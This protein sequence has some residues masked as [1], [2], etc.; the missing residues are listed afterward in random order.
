MRWLHRSSRPAPSMLPQ[1]VLVPGLGALKITIS[2]CDA[3][4]EACRHQPVHGVADAAAASLRPASRFP[5]PP[6]LSLP[7]LDTRH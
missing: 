3:A 2:E 6:D 5:L 7:E 1:Q 4:D